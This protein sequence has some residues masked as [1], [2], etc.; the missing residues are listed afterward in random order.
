MDAPQESN[1][2]VEDEVG[3]HGAINPAYL[4]SKRIDRLGAQLDKLPHESVLPGYNEPTGVTYAD[5]KQSF[6]DGL[7]FLTGM[8]AELDDPEKPILVEEVTDFAG[9]FKQFRAIMKLLNN[10]NMFFKRT[11]TGELDVDDDGVIYGDE[12]P[13]TQAVQ[14]EPPAAADDQAADESAE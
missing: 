2:E 7:N 12:K 4:I 9:A 3:V 5:I 11:K 14:A 10:K 13:P 1:I 6:V 8:V